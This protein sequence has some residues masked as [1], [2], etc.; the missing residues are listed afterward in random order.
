MDTL[1]IPIEESGGEGAVGDR[2]WG[3]A[4]EVQMRFYLVS[5]LEDEVPNGNPVR[6]RDE[7]TGGGGLRFKAFGRPV[8]VRVCH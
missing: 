1:R 7:F 8:V 6:P 3:T 4:V 2:G 5:W